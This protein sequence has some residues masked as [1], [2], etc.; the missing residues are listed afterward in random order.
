MVA[1]QSKNGK[2]N[3]WAKT[4][5]Q[6]TGPMLMQL[7]MNMGDAQSTLAKSPVIIR[8]SM[9]FPYISGLEFEYPVQLQDSI[10]LISLD[11]YL[12]RDFEAYGMARIPQYRTMRATHVWLLKTCKYTGTLIACSSLPWIYKSY[13]QTGF[14]SRLERT[15]KNRRKKVASCRTRFC[16]QLL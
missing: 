12:G 3:V 5:L 11:M 10:L 8:E 6:M 14:L 1:N 15:V 4:L 9:L 7:S 13:S 16:C 2:A